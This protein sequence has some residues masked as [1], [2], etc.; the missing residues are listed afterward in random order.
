[1]DT[2]LNAPSGAHAPFQ[3]QPFAPAAPLPIR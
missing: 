1:M 3:S 2:L